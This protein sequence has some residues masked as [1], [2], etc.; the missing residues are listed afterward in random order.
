M[1][2][3]HFTINDQRLL[4]DFNALSEIGE[5]VDGGVNRLALSNEDLQARAWFAERVDSAGLMMRDD[6]AG[7]LSGVLFCDD[8]DAQTL[9]VGSHLDTVPNGGRYDGAIGVLAGLECLRTIKDHDIKLPF[10]VEVIDFTDEEGAWQSLFGSRSLTGNFMPFNA[11]VETDHAPFRAALFRAGIR[12]MDIYKA[13]RDPDSIRAYLELHIEQGYRLDRDHFEIGIVNGIVGRI[14]YEITFKGQAAHSGTTARIHRKDA[15]LGAASFITEAHHLWD[16]DKY[17]EGIFNCG[18]LDV[19]PGA[20]NIVPSIAK[21][22][23]ELRHENQDILEDWLQDIID[24]AQEQA[25]KFELSV[26]SQLV[27]KIPV[28]SL[29]PT[30]EETLHEVSERIG[31]KYTKLTS[32]AGH[33]AQVMSAITETGLIFVPSVDG[34]SHSPREFTHWEHIIKGANVLLNTMLKLGDVI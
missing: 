12:P 29:S 11:D 26:K 5:T 21:V 10:H 1:S 27:Q 33:D 13:Q 31:V 9:I 20:F 3:T 25:D 30:I 18:K 32:F 14:N 24:L 34:I 19:F 23:F 22:K 15:L 16:E 8:K 4:V 7:N 2:N 28:A 17:N 6:D